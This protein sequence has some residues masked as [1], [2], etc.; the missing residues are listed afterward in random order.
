[1]E[2]GTNRGV[3]GYLIN[4]AD[5]L[6]EDWLAGVEKIGVT[7]GASTPDEIVQEVVE[8]L[9]ERGGKEVELCRVAEERTVFSLPG[10]LRDTDVD[11]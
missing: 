5:E 6:I 2:V 1:V 7:G 11:G 10:I 8:Y 9:R 3:S 4:D